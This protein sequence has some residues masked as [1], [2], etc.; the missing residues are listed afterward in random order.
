MSVNVNNNI[1]TNT[2]INNNTNTNNQFAITYLTNNTNTTL[3][4]IHTNSSQKNDIN[5]NTLTSGLNIHHQI[6]PVND[7]KGDIQVLYL[8][9]RSIRNKIDKLETLINMH[10][11]IHI[12]I[13]SETWLCEEETQYFN[14]SGYTHFYSTRASHAGGVSIYV[15]SDFFANAIYCKEWDNNSMLGINIRIGIKS[16]NI[17]AV[18]KQPKSKF[19]IFIHELENVMKKFHDSIFFGDFNLNLLDNGNENVSRY[20][21]DILSNGFLILNKI[22]IEHFT[23]PNNQSGSIIDHII[24]DVLDLKYTIALHDTDISDHRYVLA[25]LTFNS[26]QKNQN[27][28]YTIKVVEYDQINATNLTHIIDSDN[29]EI[30]INKIQKIINANTKL[31]TKTKSHSNAMKK[32]WMNENILNLINLNK[33]FFKL[34]SKFPRNVYFKTKFNYYRNKVNYNIQL[35]KKNYYS[36]RYLKSLDNAKMFWQTTNELLFKRHGKTLNEISLKANNIVETN[37]IIVANLFN[38]FFI[39][40]GNSEQNNPSHPNHTTPNASLFLYNTTPSEIL[41]ILKTI[42]QSS[43]SGYDSIPIKFFTRFANDIAPKLSKLINDSF[44]S[45]SFPNC[46]KVARVTPIYK[47]ADKQNVT[48]YRPISVLPTCS[49]IFERAMFNRLVKF[50]ADNKRIHVN[51]FGFITNSSTLAACTQLLNFIETKIDQR[52]IVGCMFIDIK[53]AFDCVQHSIL[54]GKLKHIGLEH[55]ALK[56]FESFHEKRKQFTK[57][58]EYKSDILEI[59]SGVPQ[60]SMLSATEFS[61]YINNI[62]NLK[63]IGVVQMYADDMVIM[64]SANNVE[65]LL[66]NFQEDIMLIDDS[67]K[68]D[69][70]TIN[71][72]KSNYIIFDKY[73]TINKTNLPNIILNT[74]VISRVTETKYLGLIIDEKLNWH[75]HINKI[76]NKVRPL[77]FAIKRLRNFL[78]EKA[79]WQVYN[80]HILSHFNYLSPIWSNTTNTKL[81]ELYILQNKAIKAMYG[82]SRLH[83]T[84]SLYTDHTSIMPLKKIFM[85]RLITLIFQIKNGYIKHNFELSYRNDVHRYPTRQSDFINIDR[86]NTNTG[87]NTIMSR[88]VHMFNNLPM[89]IKNIQNISNFKRSLTIYIQNL[90]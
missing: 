4:L 47:N 33:F 38:S 37:Q 35:A 7:V 22:A 6:N 51:Q 90:I 52:C 60:G 73:N 5:L 58:N 1:T 25:T 71:T 12:I 54:L 74:G 59:K 77:I 19:D 87:Q 9:I 76:K 2:N 84:I 63:L 20:L 31:I 18:Y 75:S 26:R 8:N 78:H 44:K 30:F 48:N 53:K 79:I 64:Y 41:T 13:L 34:K 28:T 62:F 70:L 32:P 39:N 23:R 29:T 85:I 11:H 50:L 82:Y 80:A 61:I 67:L 55:S 88:G 65:S 49:K 69:N 24:T 89:N 17:F 68:S 57:L 16:I 3:S 27:H 72:N 86:W 56:L 36:E 66:R 21:D 43:S 83:P 46:L 81:N 14:L 40:V 15:R 45:G 10:R 42:N